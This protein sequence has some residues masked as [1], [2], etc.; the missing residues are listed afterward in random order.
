MNFVLFVIIVDQ[1][2]YLQPSASDLDI[3]ACNHFQHP[4]I[5]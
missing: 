5:L 3:C 4:K 1:S 2:S